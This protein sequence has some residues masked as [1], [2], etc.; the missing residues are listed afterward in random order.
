VGSGNGGGSASV[1]AVMPT[2]LI[3]EDEIAIADTLIY[4][5]NAVGFATLH[6][7][8]LADARQRIAQSMPDLIILDL[9]LPD[10]SGLDLCRDVRRSSEVPMVMLTAM[11]DE[12]D[13]I[14]GLELGADDYVTKPFSPRE[15][16]L[17]VKTILRRTRSEH[18]ADE[19]HG[20]SRDT[21]A[22][23]ASNPAGAGSNALA[24]EI[25]ASGQRVRYANQWLDLTRRELHLLQLLLQTPGRIYSRETLLDRV[26]GRD[27]ESMERTVDTHIKTLRAKLRNAD[28]ASDPIVTHRGLGYSIQRGAND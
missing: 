5:L 21:D 10:G 1:N 20:A 14:V 18:G 8:N 9:G 17:R 13:R 6:A 24:F 27:A 2:V 12:V 15:V 25:D 28:P 7:E 4:A 11:S 3:V 16:C 26:W 22:A 19:A 23:I